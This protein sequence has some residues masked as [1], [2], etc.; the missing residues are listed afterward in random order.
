[1]MKEDWM[2]N[3][4]GKKI[5]LSE[6]TPQ[7]LL[8]MIGQE[9]NVDIRKDGGLQLGSHG[10]DAILL[11]VSSAR[12]FEPFLNEDGTDLKKELLSQA[13]ALSQQIEN[14]RKAV[15]K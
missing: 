3:P 12:D 4:P 11:L 9:D 8:Y 7:N 14:M 1:M 6:V 5:T 13:D 10:V 15:K 2:K